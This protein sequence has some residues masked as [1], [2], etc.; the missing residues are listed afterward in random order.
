MQMLLQSVDKSI[1]QFNNNLQ[2]TINKQVESN[3]NTDL[4]SSN[5][6]N[7]N[8]CDTSNNFSIQ[9][10]TNNNGKTTGPSNTSCGN[11]STSSSP[12]LNNVN[13]KGVIG[14]SEYD[15]QTGA[16]VSS[17]FGKWSLVTNEKGSSNFKASFTKQPVFYLLTNNIKSNSNTLAT[18]LNTITSSLK[19]ME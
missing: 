14:S 17:L 7:N 16:I 9:S 15:K 18:C 13:L 6:N 1:Q 5:D 3:L 8:N 4:Q 11:S 12:Y 2:S 10:Q 19:Q